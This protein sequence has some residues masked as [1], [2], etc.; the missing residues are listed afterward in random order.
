MNIR[1]T[2][3]A[4]AAGIVLCSGAQADFQ[5]ALGE[6]RAGHYDAAHQQFLA[7]AE[8]GDCSSQFNLAAMALQGQ[9]GSQDTGSG[10]GWLEAAVS[11]GCRQLV[12][13]KLQALSTKL[14]GEQQQQAAAI[15]ARYGHDA[16]QAQ[17]V[18]N[19]D[20][21]CANLTAPR[22][23]SLPRP[24]YPP[25]TSSDGLVIAVL[26]VGRD[27]HVRDPEILQALPSEAFAA[28]A[29]EAWLNSTYMPALR[30]G[31]PVSARVQTHV[32]FSD[33]PTSKLGEAAVLKQARPAAQSGDAAAEYLI[34]LSSTADPA[35]G[36]PGAAGGQLLLAAARDGDP[37]AQYWIGSQ[38]RA[39][40]ECHPHADGRV[41]LRHAADGGNPAAQVTLAADLLREGAA[42]AAAAR[43]LL[44]KAAGSDNYYVRKHVVALLAAAPLDEVRDPPT[45]LR[46]AKQLAAGDIQ[47]D[48]QMF[49]AL[50]AAYAANGDY[51]NAVSAQRHALHQAEAL[52]W[53]PAAMRARL[54]AYHNDKP[55]QGDLF[56]AD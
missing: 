25:G 22:E 7:L 4:L 30:G 12:G 53:N 27:G 38:L 15:L 56:A 24:E 5:A 48:P 42:Q 17:G 40:A 20:L 3:T 23:L 19:P 10:V 52:G 47:S 8:L 33:T 32:L 44:E 9:G 1:T 28:K 39:T 16:L 54:S 49:E 14:S 34:G 21:N 50:A 51:G 55:W 26:T 41:W 13:N 45:A 6:Y 31:Q 37:Q 18:V 46:L 29:I 43:A 2:A 35:L 36:I 11:N